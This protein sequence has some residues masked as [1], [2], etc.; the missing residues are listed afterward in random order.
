MDA[1]RRYTMDRTPRGERMRFPECNMV[2]VRQ[3]QRGVQRRLEIGLRDLKGLFSLALGPMLLVSI[4]VILALSISTCQSLMGQ[5][6]GSDHPTHVFLTR[7]IRR[8]GFRLFVRIPDL[9]NDC[10]CAAV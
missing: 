6:V 2:R 1:T 9:L 5:T 4:A 10:Y 7:R 8:N 3:R